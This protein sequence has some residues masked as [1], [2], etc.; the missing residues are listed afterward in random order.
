AQRLASLGG[1]AAVA[2]GQDNVLERERQLRG[3]LGLPVE[4]GTRL[5]PSDS[6]TLAAYRPDWDTA[7]DEAL[8]NAPA[9]LLLREQVKA[10]QLNVRLAENAR[11][12][13][14]RVGAPYDINSS[15]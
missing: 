1:G 13:D 7:L 10:D 11:L 15:G 9:L 12:P 8:N 5:V 14:L 6:P 2:G 4:D 3:L